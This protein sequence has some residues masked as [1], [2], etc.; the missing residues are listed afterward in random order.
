[1]NGPEQ[2]IVLPG[3]VDGLVR[4][5]HPH[6]AADPN[7]SHRDYLGLRT[8]PPWLTT[9]SALAF[10]GTDKTAARQ[11]F[12]AFVRDG[13]R[14]ELEETFSRKRWPAIL[15]V[16]TFIN[17]IRHRFQLGKPAHLEKPQERALVANQSHDPM[18]VINRV[19]Q[20]FGTNGSWF[21]RSRSKNNGDAKRAAIYF[22]RYTCHLSYTAIGKYVGELSDSG[23]QYHLELLKQKPIQSELWEILCSEFAIES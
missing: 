19:T 2:W 13:I 7:C 10:Y 8:P 22:L 15:G 3:T 6:P 21:R 11:L 18:V 12:D 9:D 23:V 14:K 16:K 17:K 20:I 1:M 4:K 5:T